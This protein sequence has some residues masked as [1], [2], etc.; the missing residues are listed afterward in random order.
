MS[1]AARGSPDL[2]LVYKTVA[3]PSGQLNQ[4]YKPRDLV[5]GGRP[6][7]RFL[8]EGTPPP[9]LVFGADGLLTGTP[10][11][12]GTY[13]F[14]LSA[15]DASQPVMEAQQRYVLRVLVPEAPKPQAKAPAP[16]PA[17]VPQRAMLS[18]I[19][20][21]DARVTADLE[22]NTPVSYVLNA[23]DLE[24]VLPPKDGGAALGVGGGAGAGGA[25][26]NATTGASNAASAGPFDPAAVA[27]ASRLPGAD[28]AFDATVAAATA[29]P[30]AEVPR[31][32]SSDQLRAVLTPLLDVEYPTRAMFERALEA[33]RCSY[34]L[35]RT[36]ELAASRKLR[37]PACPL[38][39]AERAIERPDASAPDRPSAPAPQKRV[40]K[41]DPQSLTL[42]DFFDQ[43]IP[44]DRRALIVATAM[45]LRPI[46]QS[47]PLAWTAAACQCAPKH[48]N[49]EVFGVVPYWSHGDAP[50]V[51]DF[52]LFTRM[53]NLGAVLKTNGDYDLPVDWDGAQSGFSRTA[54]RS[55]VAVDLVLYRREWRE[56]L[57]R[58][59]AQLEAVA[60]RAAANALALIDTRREDT[61]TAL[62][63]LM[64]PGWREP[65]RVYDGLTLFFDEVPTEGEARQ[66]YARFLERL[67]NALI[68]G[69]RANHRPYAL[70]LVVPDQLLDDTGTYR[71]EWLLALLEKASP[72]KLSDGTGVRD[73]ARAVAGNNISINYLVMLSADTD[74]MKKTLRRRIDE[75]RQMHA[76]RRVDFLESLIPVFVH[77][78]EAAPVPASPGGAATMMRDFPYIGWNFG[79]I[80][81]WPLP[82]AQVGHGPDAISALRPY[83]VEPAPGVQ[84]ACGVVCVYRLPFRLLLQA[85]VL[86]SVTVIVLF[87]WFCRIRRLGLPYVLGMFGCVI[88]TALLA[89]VI[90]MCDPTLAGLRAESWKV[91]LVAGVIALLFVL[92]L[93]RPRPPS[94]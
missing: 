47:K 49:N 5:N 50:M 94:P 28:P 79:G 40:A 13:S 53:Q 77:A 10:T 88:A 8:I 63:R 73:P 83:F 43:L 16:G 62:D 48:K 76:Q 2:R 25:A 92:Y 24:K 27:A 41:A 38:P 6:P 35:R 17:T 45:K 34:F 55:G 85:L 9:G 1:F 21:S 57:D 61:Q 74:V 91:L 15:E 33:Q 3:L 11:R 60:R 66:R 36:A 69:M 90:Y 20:A 82:L 56:M 39:A 68:D 30:L 4:P 32:A 81:M 22:A 12:A 59:D 71:F 26:A 29:P 70:N 75:T 31:G 58:D 23:Q 7:Y 18:A 87:T 37:A 89:L 84:V 80:A 19:S 86:V 14:T 52:S 46:S 65:D 78:R 54:Q 64:L 51:V 72:Q 44:A 42:D 93:F 67:M